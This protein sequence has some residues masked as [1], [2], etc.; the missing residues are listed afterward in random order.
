MGARVI[1]KREDSA[2]QKKEALTVWMIVAAVCIPVLL[3]SVLMVADMR[4]DLSELHPSRELADAGAALIGWPDLE[5]DD[6]RP[7]EIEHAAW[8][9]RARLK[10]MGYMMDGY[11]PAA[12]G[13]QVRMFIL[14]P[15][16]GVILHPAHRIPNEMVEVWLRRPVLF[17]FRDLVWVSGTLQA[18][19]N[20]PRGEMALYALK[21]AESE[22]ADQRDI[23][24]WFGPPR[25]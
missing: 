22:T 19:G 18:T 7:V 20:N 1:K 25:R 8:H 10:M 12:D 11:R 21:D 23:T 3:A 15:E 17:K 13:V 16:A 2:R 5:S 9:T 6:G 24:R 4:V 14:M